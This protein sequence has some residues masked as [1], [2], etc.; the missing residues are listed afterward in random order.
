M[1]DSNADYQAKIVR[2]LK[3]T[4]EKNK[5]DPNEEI[6]V[7]PSIKDI[8]RW[9]FQNNK[10]TVY[11]REEIVD[12]VVSVIGYPKDESISGAVSAA[13]GDLE[14]DGKATRVGKVEGYWQGNID[15]DEDIIELF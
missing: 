14:E 13:L 6:V 12:Y 10:N 8:I 2:V 15:S 9:L 5:K 3:N 1:S 11:K 4:T 7:L